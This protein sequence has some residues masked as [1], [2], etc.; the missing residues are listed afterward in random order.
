MK[1]YMTAILPQNA[2]L[3]WHQTICFSTRFFQLTSRMSRRRA[4][5]AS[6]SAPLSWTLATL[7][8]LSPAPD[9]SLR[10]GRTDQSW[11]GPEGAGW[12]PEDN[13]N[14]NFSPID[15]YS[16]PVPVGL[17]WRP[18]SCPSSSPGWAR[19]GRGW[20]SRPGSSS[21][22]W[23]RGSSCPPPWSNAGQEA[24]GAGRWVPPHEGARA[25]SGSAQSGCRGCTRRSGWT[26]GGKTFFRKNFLKL[27]L[28]IVTCSLCLSK[29]YL[30]MSSE[31]SEA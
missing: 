17:T 15:L 24:W 8:T 11:T 4:E 27:G 6:S 28:K 16:A 20:S 9:A 13:K 30:E 1:L 3:V 14:I 12:R 19:S 10:R 29:R 7:G 18:W 31:L 25:A 21:F 26:S 23:R 5:T 22:G 2:V